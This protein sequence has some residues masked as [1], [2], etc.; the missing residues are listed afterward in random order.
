MIFVT[1]GS[2]VQGFDRLIKSIDLIAEITG[3]DFYVQTGCSN[4]KP[5]NCKYSKYVAYNESENLI[6]N[7]Q[8]LICHAGIGTLILAKKYS[9]K[10]VI[11]PRFAKFKEHFNDHQSEICKII[12]SENRPN[13]A[14]VWDI[15]NLAGTVS[16]MLSQSHLL[17]TPIDINSGKNNIVNEIKKLLNTL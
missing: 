11:V 7:C 14:V 17:S 5:L 15:N 9:K 10:T 1:V 3:L 13:I 16:M 6:R 8:L 2:M 12:E 4:Y